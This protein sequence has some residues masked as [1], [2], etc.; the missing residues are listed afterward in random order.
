MAMPGTAPP[1]A[2]DEALRLDL[3]GLK[4]PLPVLRAQKE[5][6]KL[7]PGALLILECTDPMAA[8]DLPNIA[9]ETGD[10]YEGRIEGEGFTSHHLR[11][12]PGP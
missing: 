9:R 3:R 8:I 5:L 6:A 12:A 10:L 7:Q 1:F 4:C 2:S 11:K